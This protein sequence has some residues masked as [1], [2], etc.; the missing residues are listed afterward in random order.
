VLRGSLL[1]AV[2]VNLFR[3][4]HSRR[5]YRVEFRPL[6][7]D[8]CLVADAKGFTVQISDPEVSVADT[9]SGEHRRLSVKQRFTLAHEIAHTLSYDVEHLPVRENPEVLDWIVE[10]GGRP[11]PEALEGFCQ[12]AAGL[13]LVPTAALKESLGP[14]TTVDSVA[15]VLQLAKTFA[16]SPEVVIHRV[17]QTEDDDHIRAVDYALLLI[18]SARGKEE[19]T[20]CIYS[21]SLR[22]I[23]KPPRLYSGVKTWMKR[24]SLPDAIPEPDGWSGRRQEGFLTITRKRYGSSYF[25]EI[26]F[27]PEG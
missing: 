11:G 1:E 10:E 13:I 21:D 22:G 23:V 18:T 8:G 14:W 15:R 20:A 6:L 25:L 27:T 3:L 16:V 2:P 12:I 9:S 5:I 26:R 19:I 17:A 24:N 4:A 7:A